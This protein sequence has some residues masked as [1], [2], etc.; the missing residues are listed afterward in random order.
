MEMTCNE[1]TMQNNVELTS[2]RATPLIF[3]VLP[4]DVIFHIQD[5]LFLISSVPPIDMKLGL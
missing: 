2:F 5:S 4:L 1:M 3:G